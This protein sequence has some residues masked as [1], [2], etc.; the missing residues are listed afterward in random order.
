MSDPTP[1]QADPTIHLAIT[2]KGEPGAR[3]GTILV[4]PDAQPTRIRV[5]RYGEETCETREL[6]SAAELP[7]ILAQSNDKLWIEV[8]GL[9]DADTLK[10]TGEALGLHPLVLEDVVNVHQRPKVE[11]Y[12]N[13]LFIILRFLYGDQVTDTE[14]LS[15]YLQEGRVV[16]FCER[17]PEVFARVHKRLQDRRARMRNRDSSYLAYAQMDAVV[18]AFFPL[19]E[20]YG[21]RIEA[22][23]SEALDNPTPDTLVEIRANKR[24]LLLLRRM[25]WPTREMLSQLLR[26]TNAEISEETKLFLRDCYDHSVQLIDITDGYRELSSGLMDVYLSS[27]G[28]KMNEVMRVLT[29]V[30]TIFIPLT[31]LAGIY[32]MNFDGEKSPYN[33]PELRWQ[34]AYPVFLVINLSI[35]LAML[36]FFWR[37]GWLALPK[38]SQDAK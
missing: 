1:E 6:G 14:Q 17:D 13:G 25:L 38:R 5:T 29:V 3:P 4:D 7:E 15:I 34:Y 27:A 37:L 32:G 12:D 36:W 35:G 22:M 10:A 20:G 26:D 33:M 9:G 16:T 19:L 21:E 28:H 30:A 8:L 2:L 11:T 31:F 23:E 24:E 18:D